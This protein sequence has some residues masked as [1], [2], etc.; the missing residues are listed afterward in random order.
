MRW[1]KFFYLKLCERAEIR[2]CRAPSC[3]V[4]KMQVECFGSEEAPLSV[5]VRLAGTALQA[6]A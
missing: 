1:K 5:V 6:T 4:C 3:G 2:A